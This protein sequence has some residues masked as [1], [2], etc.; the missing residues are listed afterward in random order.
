MRRDQ[1]EHPDRGRSEVWTKYRRQQLH[2][3]KNIHPFTALIFHSL[4]PE[5]RNMLRFCIRNWG[6][7]DGGGTVGSHTAIKIIYTACNSP[8]CEEEEGLPSPKR[9]AWPPTPLPYRQEHLFCSY[10]GVLVG[11]MGFTISLLPGFSPSNNLKSQQLHQSC[12][13]WVFTWTPCAMR[14][15]FSP[16]ITQL[17]QQLPLY[18]S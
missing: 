17:K 15:I 11:L 6:R 16:Q 10:W 13:H 7:T 14:D 4:L 9:P 18:L 3:W 5:W 12:F 1:V 2:C 8:T